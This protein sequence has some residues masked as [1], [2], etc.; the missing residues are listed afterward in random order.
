M[1]DLSRL[2]LPSYIPRMGTVTLRPAT[3]D[4]VPLLT[5]W[6]TQPHVIA[7]TG[8]DDVLD[9]PAELARDAAWTRTIIGEE[10]GRPFGVVQIIDPREEETHYW[11]DVA[12][13]LRA[14]D[15]WIGEPADL[16]RGLGTDLMRLTLERCFADEDVTA[17]LIDPLESNVR[18][19]VF[20][21]RIGFVQVGPRRFGTDDCM[22]YRLERDRW[23]DRTGQ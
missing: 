23:R 2:R 8:D 16:G 22:V 14:I 4:D 7:A 11:G 3:F 18:A 12:P 17:V 15:I 21:E 19:R 10:D 13:H 5:L 9:W 6:D 20:Y 1:T